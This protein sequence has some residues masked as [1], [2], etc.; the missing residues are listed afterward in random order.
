MESN[1]TVSRYWNDMT[2][3]GFELNS[4]PVGPNGATFGF[5]EVA[6]LGQTP[7]APGTYTLAVSDEWGQIVVL[8]FTVR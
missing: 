7:F 2:I 5:P 1:R 6:P 3:N 4:T 8:P